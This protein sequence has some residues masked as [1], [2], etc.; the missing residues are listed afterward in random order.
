[1]WHRLG[2]YTR[3]IVQA[4]NMRPNEV[5]LLPPTPAHILVR[6]FLPDHSDVVLRIAPEGHLAREVFFGRTMAQH[7]FPAP[8]ILHHDHR[9]TLVP[10]DYLL[11]RFVGGIPAAHLGD[12][13]PLLRN[14]ARQVGR[15]LRRMHR[16]SVP[17]WGSPGSTGRWSTVSWPEVLASLQKTFAPE[18]VAARL[19]DADQL[20]G[21][22]A[23]LADPANQC[24]HPALLHGDL[25]LHTVRCTTGERVNLEALL[26]PGPVVGGDG[27]LDLAWTFTDPA[28]PQAW[29]TGL[30]EGY[31]AVA[32]LRQ[33]EWERL[34]TLRGLVAFWKTCQAYCRGEPFKAL[35]DQALALLGERSPPPDPGQIEPDLNRSYITS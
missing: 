10:F 1:M 24:P 19:F 35:R 20:A 21:F 7:H 29:R 15:V 13:P 34:Q 5:R 18:S 2:D 17:G 14:L 26:D 4:M 16:L 22:A 6:L 33:D 11:E 30:V 27:L 12:D 23:L 3:T 31:I 9:R 25:S 32:P 8:C 28:S